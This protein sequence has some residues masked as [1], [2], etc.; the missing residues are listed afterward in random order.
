MKILFVE[1]LYKGH[2][3]SLYA[4]KLIDKFTK[5]NLV[6]FLKTSRLQPDLF[7]Q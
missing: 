5:K 3:I 7:S 2:H 6:Y 4:K 1:T